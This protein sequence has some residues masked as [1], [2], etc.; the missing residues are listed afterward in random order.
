MRL[1]KKKSLLQSRDP[2]RI[3][4]K[5]N[6]A[7]RDIRG[8][9]KRIRARISQL[10]G[11]ENAFALGLVGGI[12]TNTRYRFLTDPQKVQEF[13]ELLA[14]LVAEE[15]LI[16]T[17]QT[18][19]W[20]EPYIDSAYK[21]GV[22]RSWID[23]NRLVLDVSDDVLGQTREAFLRQALGS[24]ES[25]KKLQL[26]GTRAYTTLQGF[27]D[28]MAKQLSQ[29][30]VEGLANGLQP[31]AVAKQMRERIDGLSKGRAGTIARTEIIHAHA[32]GQLDGFAAMGIE[33]VQMQAEW[34][35]AGDG[36][37]C[38]KC[39]PLEGVVM[40]VKKAR[41]LIPRHPNCRCAWLP[42]DP[43]FP[44]PGQH[45]GNAAAQRIGD[46]LKAETGKKRKRDAQK[47][48]RWAGAD[49][50]KVTVSKKRGL[51]KIV[52]KKKRTRVVVR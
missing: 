39:Q 10:V 22:K 17:N 46:S 41:G 47:A 36:K 5:R 1:R 45:R 6:K 15:W 51:K 3:A 37:V 27:T 28:E 38:P 12:T 44:E 13:R 24:A 18:A 32:E 31:G 2:T 25:V 35:T 29:V 14:Q 52:P 30:L 26:L 11:K 21:Q 33:N 9:L 49:V 48:S 16:S 7:V 42:A 20:L 50:V 40:S 19:P 43:E 34:V 4:T 23:A 8:R